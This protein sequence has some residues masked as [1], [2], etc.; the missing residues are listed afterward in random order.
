MSTTQDS[1]RRAHAFKLKILNRGRW[2]PVLRQSARFLRSSGTFMETFPSL[3]AFHALRLENCLARLFMSSRKRFSSRRS[4]RIVIGL[5]IF[6]LV[7]LGVRQLSGKTSASNEAAHPAPAAVPIT[8]SIAT[9]ENVPEIVNAIGTVQS[10]DSVAVQP[11]VTGAIEK[12]EFAPGQPVKQ[13]QE[14]FLIDPR[15]YQAALDQTKAQLAHDQGVLA[16]AKM[17]LSRYQT[18]QKQQS[19]AKQTAQDQVFVVQQDEG[20]VQLDQA[21]VETA[22]LNLDF[23]HIT[24][25]VSGLAGTLQIDLG[26]LVGPASGGQTSGATVSP[27]A[28]GFA[29]GTGVSNSAGGLSSSSGLVTI[30]QMQPIYVNFSIPQTVLSEVITNQ[31]KGELDVTAYSQAGTLLGKGKLTV[32]NNQVSTATGTATLQ[33]TFANTHEELWPGEYISV[34]LVVGTRRNAVTVPAS[35]VLVGPS[36]YY[37]YVIGAAGKVHRVDVQQAVRQGGISVIS[38]GISA[39]QKV[40]ATGQYRLNNGSSVAILQTTVPHESARATA[41]EGAATAD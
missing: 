16:E 13:G 19:I 20:T 5:A 31:A 15:P 37:A 41:D 33:A 35:A 24:A 38:K 29:S 28:Q 14:L 36:G 2:L 10:I 23:C 4:I 11:R 7:A 9:R 32:I 18:L 27:G 12:I 34:Q 25:P 3:S 30:V 22:Q 40:V 6:A 8:A 26:N 1:V 21:N 17:D 39:G